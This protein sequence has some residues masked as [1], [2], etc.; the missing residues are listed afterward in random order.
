MELSYNQL[1]K[2]EVINI[3][4]GKSLGF[5]IDLT[6]S[7]PKGTLT[8]I[9]VPGNKKCSLLRIF[10]RNKIF[11]EEKRIIKIGSDVIL[12]NIRCGDT[13]GDNVDLNSATVCPPKPP[14][15]RQTCPPPCPPPCPPRHKDFPSCEELF[16]DSQ[17]G[18]I[19]TG[20]Y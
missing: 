20:D 17:N 11:I 19:D 12:V 7:F 6:L 9:T 18:R 8:G 14:T 3:T 10:D 16:S 5:I 13:C 4:D 2:R 15:N 1:K